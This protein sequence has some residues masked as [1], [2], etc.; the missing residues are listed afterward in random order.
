M[1][2]RNL[3]H[4]LLALALA[5]P[6]AWGC[7]LLF[8]E[9]GGVEEEPNPLNNGYFCECSFTQDEGGIEDSVTESF[10][11]A[12]EQDGS[13][14]VDGTVLDFRDDNLTAVRFP[15]LQVPQGSEIASAHVTFI[16][17]SADSGETEI[18][19]FAENSVFGGRFGETDNNISG[20][21]LTSNSVSWTPDAWMVEA[22]ESTPDLT[23]I[24]EPLINDTDLAKW[25]F[26]SGF[27]I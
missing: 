16:S 19:I 10:D 14:R 15:N 2:F 1:S 17:H 3:Y 22:P 20:R 5:I 24:I 13:M 26:F 18:D 27:G 6:L 25:G 23:E 4:L 11:D 12:E 7:S 21:D 9:D 8:S